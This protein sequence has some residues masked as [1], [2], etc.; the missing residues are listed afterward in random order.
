MGEDLHSLTANLVTGES[1]SDVS[2]D[3]VSFA[4]VVNS[5]LIYGMEAEKF[6]EYSHDNYGITMTLQQA[7]KFRGNFFSA[8]QGIFQWHEDVELHSYDETRTLGNRSRL[9]RRSYYTNNVDFLKHRYTEQSPIFLRK[10][11]A[12]S[13]KE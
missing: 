5:G 10:H 8:Y 4:E 6:A 1:I 12:F 13:M 9:W 7:E 2:N 11:Y 3:R